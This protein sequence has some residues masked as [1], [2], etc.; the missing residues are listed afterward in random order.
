MDTARRVYLRYALSRDPKI[1][2][3]DFGKLR[4]AL[5]HLEKA[6]G[7]LDEGQNFHAYSQAID[8]FRDIKYFL[9]H[10]GVS[11]GPI[12][13]LTAL[14]KNPFIPEKAVS[15]NADVFKDALKEVQALEMEFGKAN[16]EPKKAHF[17]G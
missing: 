5:K 1:V 10:A 11:A 4:D 6:Q 16:K 15:E 12:P 14:S 7:K 2:E 9:E 8:S 3:K 13:A 17:G